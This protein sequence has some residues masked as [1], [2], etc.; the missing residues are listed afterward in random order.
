MALSDDDKQWITEAIGLG[1]A[2]LETLVTDFKDSLEREMKTG[3][4]QVNPGWTIRQRA[5]NARV[6]SSKLGAAGRQNSTTGRRRRTTN[7][8]TKD[9]QIQDLIRRV[10]AL[11]KRIP[12]AA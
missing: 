3:F 6:R 9:K 5:W 4:E 1:T 10:E 12:P 2:S 11:E 7:L 8:E